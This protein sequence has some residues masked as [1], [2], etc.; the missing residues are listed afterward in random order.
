MRRLIPV[1]VVLSTLTLVGCQR[2]AGPPTSTQQPATIAVSGSASVTAVPDRL[3]LS[4][5]VE[6][7]GMDIPSLK[8]KVDSITTKLIDYLRKQGVDDSKI[9][10]YALRVYPQNRYDNG[11]QKL[12]GYQVSRRL[13]IDFVDP[14]QH[15]PFIQF[16]LA[17]GVQRVDPPQLSL[18]NAKQLYQQA[19]QK[20]LTVARSKAEQMAATAATEIIAVQSIHEGSN[21]APTVRYRVPQAAM[22]SG[23]ESLPGEQAV[24]AHVNVVYQLKPSN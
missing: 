10:S 20:A 11:E 8:T 19:L 9:Q 3:Q 4:L 17:N 6:R 7:M 18:S 16:A 24:E 2:S 14:E 15:S 13:I 5:T 22:D 1:I 21:Q 23:A 12:I